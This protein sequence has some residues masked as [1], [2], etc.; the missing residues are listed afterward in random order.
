VPSRLPSRGTLV[1]T[2]T[3]PRPIE[4]IQPG[5]Y[6]TALAAGGTPGAIQVQS[7][8]VTANRLWQVDTEDGA[9][10]TTQNQPL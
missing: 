3:G 2:P 4:T 6:V 7:V 10:L 1:H 9:L 5:D 8:F